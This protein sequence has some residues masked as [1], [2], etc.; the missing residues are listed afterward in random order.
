MRHMNVL[1]SAK[2]GASLQKILSKRKNVVLL[3][4][5]EVTSYDVNIESKQ[6]AR[7]TLKD[8]ALDCD[9]V[10]L[11]NGP[12]APFHL[13]DHFGSVIPMMNAQGYVFDVEY[14]DKSKHT[15]MNLR[16]DESPYSYS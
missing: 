13:Y 10:V 1:D 7:V 12:Q 6:V 9:V 16:L 11:C 2:M 4:S 3:N 8:K 15:G 5:A 14:A